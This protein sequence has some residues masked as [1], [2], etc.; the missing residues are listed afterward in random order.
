M[1]CITRPILCP[2]TLNQPFLGFPVTAF[3]TLQSTWL[4]YFLGPQYDQDFSFLFC[5]LG[6]CSFVISYHPLGLHSL[7]YETSSFY[8]RHLSVDCYQ[9]RGL[10]TAAFAAPRLNPACNHECNT[11]LLV[12]VYSPSLQKPLVFVSQLKN[13]YTVM[14]IVFY[15]PEVRTLCVEEQE[16]CKRYYI[17]SCFRSISCR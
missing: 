13:M 6:N 11:I 3:R 15:Q 12:E 14:T 8:G 2:L 7:L 17:A 5:F 10:G 16:A 1:F 4:F 9:E